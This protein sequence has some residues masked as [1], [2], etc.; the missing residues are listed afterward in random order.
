MKKFVAKENDA[1]VEYAL[2]DGVNLVGRDEQ[3]DVVIDSPHISRNHLSVVISRDRAVIQDL[4]SRNG[5]FVNGLRV[6]NTV[7]IK[8]GDIVSLGKFAM[9]FIVDETAE[10]AA[11]AS[12][13]VVPD[14]ES[15]RARQASDTLPLKK[16]LAGNQ[17]EGGTGGNLPTTFDPRR[18][19]VMRHGQKIVVTDSSTGQA[20]EMYRGTP[21]AAL[22]D[23]IIAERRA[24]Q[25][26]NTILAV[27][28]GLG[29]IVAIIVVA[30]AL[31]GNREK[32]SEKSYVGKA[33]YYETIN[34]AVIEFKNK[35]DVDRAMELL[36]K[37]EA[38]AKKSKRYSLHQQI[39]SLINLYDKTQTNRRYFNVDE[40]R[41]ILEEIDLEDI[42]PS[43]NTSELHEWIS[44]QRIYVRDLRIQKRQWEN[45]V[46]LKEK[47]DFR[48]ALKAFREIRKGSVFYEDAKKEIDEI[49]LVLIREILKRSLEELDID[50]ITPELALEQI[51]GLNTILDEN[52]VPD[53]RRKSV[54][55]YRLA[56]IN[57]LDMEEK[58]KESME[59]ASILYE[60]GE[61]LAAWEEI[62]YL[63][64]DTN[65]LIREE[66]SRIKVALQ[67][68]ND[69]NEAKTLYD[70]GRADK[71][72]DI[73]K[74]R[75]I[76]H[77][78]WH[79]KYISL[80]NKIKDV[81]SNFIAAKAALEI[82]DVVDAR[83]LY[84]TILRIEEGEENYYNRAATT[85]LDAFDRE[86]EF[87]AR[88]YADAYVQ[89]AGEFLDD[90]EFLKARDFAI[91]AN[92]IDDDTQDDRNDG[93][94]IFIEISRI[95][96]SKLKQAR[97]LYKNG[98]VSDA[99]AILDY[100]L[101]NQIYTDADSVETVARGN[102]WDWK[103]ELDD[104]E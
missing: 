47:N 14:D 29:V 34:K 63:E 70:N 67:L 54:I 37:A 45:G 39:R 19:Q 43:Y 32:K 79:Q 16:H 90:K 44:I 60:E 50:E 51:D 3:C 25:R 77:Y 30:I 71:S 33:Y 92:I 72:L 94:K 61:Y 101:Q 20:I 11:P 17:A 36:K 2:N 58:K 4:N 57:R 68:G 24:R 73:L 98:K 1:T 74:D 95:G 100:I 38:A 99:I 23:K 84:N 83:D 66:M 15:A 56:C 12:A 91:K 87:S 21:D 97:S 27:L 75:N 5:T 89:K 48:S 93:K 103:R 78:E 28:G 35:G 46:A 6:K 81:Q 40:A 26:R 80:K 59:K 53:D 8:S 76:P 88:K 18:Y 102:R 7:K 55:E 96:E 41:R 82:N 64:N 86:L 13:G 49:G 22:L 104:I 42:P 65:P 85:W 62:K 10:N 31:W 52:I 9:S 69:F